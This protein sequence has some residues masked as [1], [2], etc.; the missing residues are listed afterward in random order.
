[1]IFLLLVNF[2]FSSTEF[3]KCRTGDSKSCDQLADS[4]SKDGKAELASKI[5]TISCED[6]K[7]SSSCK[8][9]EKLNL[10]KEISSHFDQKY[11]AY[12]NE[13]NK[14]AVKGSVKKELNYEIIASSDFGLP[15]FRFNYDPTSTLTF[16]TVNDSGFNIDASFLFYANK[17]VA[18]G[19]T[20]FFSYNKMTFDYFDGFIESNTSIFSL[21]FNIL[22]NSNDDILN[23]HFF[24]LGFGFWY[25]KI[26]PEDTYDE[27]GYLLEYDDFDDF[28]FVIPVKLGKRFKIS[29]T[30]AYSPNFEMETRISP[31][32]FRMAVYPISF[33]FFM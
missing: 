4:L 24:M 30:V 21:T 18:F 23:S 33:S 2:L 28:S 9:L 5:L 7:N 22:I 8:K 31:L 20:P 17:Q 26:S 32:A 1:M 14:D 13:I 15:Y 29:D 16:D 3:E 12:S 11:S 6:F 19:V 27:D 25:Y 10:E